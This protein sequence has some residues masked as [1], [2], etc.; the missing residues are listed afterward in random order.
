M[1]QS[2]TANVSPTH[3]RPLGLFDECSIRI[4]EIATEILKRT[5]K[6]GMHPVY[7][8]VAVHEQTIKEFPALKS[9]VV[10]WVIDDECDCVNTVANGT[11]SVCLE[12]RGRLVMA[13]SNAF[14]D[15]DVAAAL[16]KAAGTLLQT[17]VVSDDIEV[18]TD[19]ACLRLGDALPAGDPRRYATSA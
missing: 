3:N 13:T 14:T 5:D 19:S 1:K 18:R 15:G 6:D 8:I 17:P 16:A 9:N 4:V 10:R 12:P 7:L 2:I 11:Y